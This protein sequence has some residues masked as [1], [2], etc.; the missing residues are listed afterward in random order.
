MRLLLPPT[1]PRADASRRRR[2]FD[3]I[4]GPYPA[5]LGT[6]DG[7]ARQCADSPV[8]AFLGDPEQ[9]AA[10]LDKYVRSTDLF[11]QRVAQWRAEKKDTPDATEPGSGQLLFD[12][13][14]QTVVGHNFE[15]R[16][17]LPSDSLTL[18]LVCGQK[19][20]ST[21]GGWTKQPAR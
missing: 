18:R 6:E 11:R 19:P 15:L 17:A 14:A 10:S 12:L 8:T 3:P 20:Y 1:N 13:A 5:V 16:L 7:R 4:A 2:E 21:N 9:L